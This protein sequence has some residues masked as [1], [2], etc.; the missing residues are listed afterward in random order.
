MGGPMRPGF[1]NALVL[2]TA[3]SL[4]PGERADAGIFGKIFGGGKS[5]SV[6]P[7][8]PERELAAMPR[9]ELGADDVP[10]PQNGM[11]TVDKTFPGGSYVVVTEGFMRALE[12]HSAPASV[13]LRSDDPAN[14]LGIGFSREVHRYADYD[15]SELCVSFP[16]HGEKHRDEGVRAEALIVSH[17]VEK[18]FDLLHV[19]RINGIDESKAAGYILFRKD[20]EERPFWKERGFL[21]GVIIGAQIQIDRRENG[22]LERVDL[23]VIEH[24]RQRGMLTGYGGNEIVAAAPDTSITKP[25]VSSVPDV[26]QRI[27][28]GGRK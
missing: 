3:L 4:V 21:K 9:I 5:K 12:G 28:K 7:Y 18:H 20:L 26:V 10:P 11:I 16:P 1:F 8:N 19:M 25:A 23:V 17:G 14:P 2:A 6:T 27:E 15:D 22:L 24:L 13:T